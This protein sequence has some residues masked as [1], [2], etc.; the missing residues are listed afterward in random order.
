MKRTICLVCLCLA[1]LLALGCSDRAEGAKPAPE[2][3]ATPEQTAAPT[4]AP[5]AVPTQMPLIP[6]SADAFTAATAKDAAAQI[7]AALSQSPCYRADYSQGTYADYVSYDEAHDSVR[8]LLE[9]GTDG[10]LLAAL[11]PLTETGK[12]TRLMLELEPDATVT[13]LRGVKELILTSLD[14]DNAEWLPG[15]ADVTSL[16]LGEAS[17]SDSVAY[18]PM[19]QSLTLEGDYAPL[20]ALIGTVEE[21]LLPE[22][23]TLS[24]GSPESEELEAECEANTF[25]ALPK[26]TTLNLWLAPG[27][28]A[29]RLYRQVLSV[30]TL[31]TL[32]GIAKGAYGMYYGLDV[33]ATMDALQEM[34]SAAADSDSENKGVVS[35]TS[36]LPSDMVGESIYVRIGSETS[37]NL[38][39]DGYVTSESTEANPGEFYGIP[40]AML[41]R[42]GMSQRHVWVA[43]IYEYDEIVGF[44]GE[45]E[46]EIWG[47]AAE[48]RVLAVDTLTGRI[49][50]A[51]A[52]RTNPP[53]TNEDD[54][55]GDYCPLAAIEQLRVRLK[56]NLGPYAGCTLEEAVQAAQDNLNNTGKSFATEGLPPAITGPLYVEKYSADGNCAEADDIETSYDATAGLD[57]YGIPYERIYQDGSLESAAWVAVIIERD[58]ATRTYGDESFYT[59]GYTVETHLILIDLAT[60]QAWHRLVVSS[61]PP[62]NPEDT[63]YGSFY[64]NK[65]VALLKPLVK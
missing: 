11:A 59:D 36:G 42:D 26:L 28:D 4:P 20:S 27:S 32:N 57:Y 34:V 21:A 41:W 39:G 65:A 9:S 17:L 46:N 12:L 33:M 19:L 16:I 48:T 43:F 40:Y 61:P 5:T 14:S 47:Y 64:P 50:K 15:F 38:E 30:P 54:T 23:T 8:L 24:V 37:T 31:Q 52:K 62:A 58:V 56:T 1:A 51:T 10:E 6:L 13:P 44:Y 22:L 25:A 3:T 45:R 63:N 53:A 55:Y 7:R 2:A 49:F 29:Q 18:P 35:A 60:G